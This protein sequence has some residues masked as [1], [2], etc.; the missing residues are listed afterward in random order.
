MLP[1]NR[2]LY[3]IDHIR[4][5]VTNFIYQFLAVE[6]NNRENHRTETQV[7]VNEAKCVHAC[8]RVRACVCVRHLL[9]AHIT[10]EL[11]SFIVIVELLTALLHCF[12]FTMLFVSRKLLKLYSADWWYC[13]PINLSWLFWFAR[14]IKLFFSHSFAVRGRADQQDLLVPIRQFL[15]FLLLPRLLRASHPRRGRDDIWLFEHFSSH[16]RLFFWGFFLFFP[17]IFYPH[18]FIYRVY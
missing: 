10:V 7:R 17:S 6:L 11:H 5:Q 15:R 1:I 2:L 4:L 12:P 14:R 9:T 13:S 8:A 16:A 3:G 18:L